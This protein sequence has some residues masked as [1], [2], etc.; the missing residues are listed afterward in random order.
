MP[1]ICLTKK[2]TLDLGKEVDADMNLEKKF[3][4]E[5]RP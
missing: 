5:V 3:Q 2:S 4:Q 1:V